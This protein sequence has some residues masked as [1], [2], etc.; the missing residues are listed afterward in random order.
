MQRKTIKAIVILIVL[1]AVV[2]AAVSFSFTS[3]QS[4]QK[5]EGKIR[6]ATTI[7]PYAGFIEKVGGERVDVIVLVPPGADPHAFEPTPSSIKAV[8][9]AIVYFKVGADLEFELNWLD[10]LVDLNPSMLLVDTS[11]GLELIG[12]GGGK[13]PHVWLSPR[14]AMLIV[15]SIY[16][17]LE[18]ADP[19][20]AEF[21]R[22]NRDAYIRALERLDIEVR[23]GLSRLRAREFVV[24]HSTWAY[25]A[26]DYGLV[27]IALEEE[28]KEPTIEE[29]IDVI[30]KAK[31]SGVKAIFA[32]PGYDP[33]TLDVIAMDI[34]VQ[35]ILV[36]P[37][38]TKDYITII[39]QFTQYLKE[40]VG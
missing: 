8:S 28:G 15:D 14:N 10:R 22:V 12:S 1:A 29:I 23:E 38:S 20:G 4:S 39:K 16:R 19:E 40:A 18:E 34:G 11:E 32:E 25:F 13:D 7:T 35:I 9:E 26:R 17:G 36:D 33:G 27:Q 5:P 24:Y 31:E 3:T 30:K 37:H 6:V 21:Y 2:V